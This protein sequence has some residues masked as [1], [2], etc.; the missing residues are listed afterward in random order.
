M[1]TAK[2]QEF[3]GERQKS[4]NERDRRVRQRD[5]PGKKQIRQQRQKQEQFHRSGPFHQREQT[6]GILQDH[7]FVNHRQFEMGGG[8]VHRQSPV[9]GQRHDKE[10]K[11]REQM[12]GVQHQERLGGKT[13][14][15]AIETGRTGT[16]SDAENRDQHRRLGQRGNGNL[17]ARSHATKR[18][19]CI[20]PRQREKESAE[21]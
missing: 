11:E 5:A 10:R 21:Q 1:A 14:D 9:L 18:A 2:M 3:N 19:P 8:I 20:Q 13:R 12:T 6:A 15:D 7:R 16:Q 4:A 17:T